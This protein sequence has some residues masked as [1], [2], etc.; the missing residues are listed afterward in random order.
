MRRMKQFFQDS[1]KK[2]LKIVIGALLVT[3]GL[4][5]IFRE[6]WPLLLL[7]FGFA[8]FTIPLPKNLQNI[9]SI[10]L[11]IIL[12]VLFAFIQ[13]ESILFWGL[14]LQASPLLYSSLALFVTLAIM[15][16]RYKTGKPI[17][18]LSPLRFNK[19]DVLII[20]PALL[21]TG[22]LYTRV[23]LPKN[24]DTVAMMQSITHGMDDVTHM[25]IFGALLRTDGTLL[26]R[27]PEQSQMVSNTN[28][29]YPMGWHITTSLVAA[30]V[31]DF[32]S[33]PVVYQLKAYF[34][35]KL[36]TLFTTVLALTVFLYTLYDRI[37]A[38]LKTVGDYTLFTLAALFVT[39]VILLPLYFEGFF[40]FLPILSY[41][42]IF[43]T[44]LLSDTHKKP[45]VTDIVLGLLVMATALTWALSAPVLI[46]AMISKRIK[47]AGSLRK[48]PWSFYLGLGIGIAG[49]L[50]QAKILLSANANVA[51]NIVNPGGITNPTDWLVLLCFGV[52]VA[53]WL[54]GKRTAAASMSNLATVVI[55][56][57]L[58][59]SGLLFVI[60]L[61]SNELSYYYYKFQT[62]LLVLLLP[63]TIL[64][65][66]ELLPTGKR[67]MDTISRTALLLCILGI[68]IPSVIGFG[69]IANINDRLQNNN[70]SDQDVSRAITQSLDRRF[71]NANER[72]VSL[73]AESAPRTILLTHLARQAYPNDKCDQ[74]LFQNV[75]NQNVE[76][77][78]EGLKN[79]KRPVNLTINTNRDGA[80]RMKQTLKEK[81]VD[82]SHIRI[83]I[84]ETITPP[85]PI[86]P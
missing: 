79:C 5:F 51:Q 56:A 50:V 27:Q 22:A 28:S 68:S 3:I 64:L 73:Y 69:Y 32:D 49:S 13:L 34:Y 18:E 20:L 36:F 16:V 55:P 59:L 46:I 43:T 78:A 65:I 1:K 53:A 67:W 58:F 45:L 81:N 85:P 76:K 6:T 7:S 75:Y 12:F 48:L 42:L 10:R 47:D 52:F 37:S 72:F 4:C 60:S 19:Y 31:Y 40:S 71:S 9:T 70:L 86:K 74:I 44:L 66:I 84:T 80:T 14:H 2:E 11:L 30:S 38:K 54:K 77:I 21:V 83:N 15:A 17:I 33:K 63:V 26:T 61:S 8:F 25:G 29:S 23:I 82:M 57:V 41:L 24:D 35:A 62:V 39:Y